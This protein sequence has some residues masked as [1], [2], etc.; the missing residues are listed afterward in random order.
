MNKTGN[1]KNNNFEKKQKKELPHTEE[2]FRKAKAKKLIRH[3]ERNKDT[4]HINYKIQHL[5]YDPF[6]FVNAY[7][8]INK[9]KKALTKTHN[10]NKIIKIFGEKSAEKITKKIKKNKYK[11]KPIKNVWVPKPGTKQKRPFIIPTQADQIVQEAIRGILEAIYEPVFYQQSKLTNG[12]SNNYGFRPNKSCWTAIKQLITFSKRCNI[13][14]KGSIVSIFKKVNHELLLKMLTKKI[15]DK[16]FLN[17]IKK[18]LKLGVM[19]Q[20]TFM[21]SFKGPLQ[22]SNVSP[23]LFNIYMLQFDKFVY[24][25]IITPILNGNQSKKDK[26][27]FS[28]YNKAK[29]KKT[30]ALNNYRI[31]KKIFK[32][33]NTHSSKIILKYAKKILKQKSLRLLKVFYDNDKTTKKSAVFVRYINNW[34]LAMTGEKKQAQNIKNKISEFFDKELQIKLNNK[35]TKIIPYSKGFK[36]LGF[37]IKMKRKK[38]RLVQVLTKTVKGKKEKTLRRTTS[39]NVTVSPDNQK[40]LKK[41]KKLKMFKKNY[42]PIGKPI[43]YSYDEFQIVQKYA[44]IMRGI[45]NYYKPCKK[46]NKLYHISYI[47]KFSCAKTIAGRKK[48]SMPKVFQ[49]YGKNLII[50]KQI[51]GKKKYKTIIQKFS[52]IIALKAMEKKPILNFVTTA[53]NQ[54]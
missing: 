22:K 14:I 1:I 21:H 5:L 41:L 39:R 49:K 51:G 36:F 33:N 13:I 50:Q 27:I 32:L 35:K 19:N 31:A 23:L 44:K 20:N 2:S 52:D 8:K 29:Y 38:T 11:F 40:I 25:K 24:E 17:L 42:F 26:I 12:L 9:N 43:W 47:L 6:T 16:L 34:V 3:A 53:N 46:L 7:T 28:R 10:K 45:F 48:I 15:K 37:E 18:M 4:T 30:K 54:F